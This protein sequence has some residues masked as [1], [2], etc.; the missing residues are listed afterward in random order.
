MGTIWLFLVTSITCI[1]I[2]IYIPSLF[3]CGLFLLLGVGGAMVTVSLIVCIYY[4]VI[5][6]YTVYYMV[7]SFA[8][9]VPWSKCDPSWADMSTCYV[10]GS[11][12]VST[13]P[14]D[15]DTNTEFFELLAM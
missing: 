8:S 11:R 9:E 3:N 15:V 10:R 4:N 7:S 14:A 12:A 13:N 1:V 5:M 6:S 2:A